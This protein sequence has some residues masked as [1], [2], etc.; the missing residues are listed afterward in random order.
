MNK[1][2]DGEWL[3][4]INLDGGGKQPAMSLCGWS[5]LLKELSDAVNEMERRQALLSPESC[6]TDKVKF[7][8]GYTPVHRKP[9]TY[10][11]TFK[12]TW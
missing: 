8:K 10:S 6:D 3:D 7:Q 9:Q 2:R 12:V 4:Q 5:G 1:Q 11:V